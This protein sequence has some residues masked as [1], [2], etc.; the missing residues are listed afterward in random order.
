MTESF[1]RSDLLRI[2]E[3]IVFRTLAIVG[4]PKAQLISLGIA[5]IQARYWKRKPTLCDVL[6][7]LNGYDSLYDYLSTRRKLGGPLRCKVAVQVGEVRGYYF[8]L[9][10]FFRDVVM[11]WISLKRGQS[12]NSGIAPLRGKIGGQCCKRT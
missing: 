1:F 3:Y 12:L 4:H 8:N 10:I 7:P 5:Q 6:S 11:V 2:V 9:A